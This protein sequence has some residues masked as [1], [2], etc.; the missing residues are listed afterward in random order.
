MIYQS[1]IR[2]GYVV[3]EHLDYQKWWIVVWLKYQ[4]TVELRQGN[5]Y[6][7]G[8]NVNTSVCIMKEKETSY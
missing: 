7:S 6:G 1:R 3:T 4:N 2:T 5:A 8:R